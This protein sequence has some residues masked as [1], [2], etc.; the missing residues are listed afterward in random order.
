MVRA[1][2]LRLALGS[3]S[4]PRGGCCRRVSLRVAS[5]TPLWW[6]VIPLLVVS[7]GHTALAA[8]EASGLSARLNGTRYGALIRVTDPTEIKFRAPYEITLWVSLASVACCVLA[9]ALF[10]I[11]DNKTLDIIVSA[12]TTLLVTWSALCLVSLARLF[13]LHER[14]AL[15]RGWPPRRLDA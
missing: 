14:L 7:L 8:S 13:A 6:W 3:A 9:A 15:M 4:R 5:V 10:S 1:A 11:T 2:Q 12:G